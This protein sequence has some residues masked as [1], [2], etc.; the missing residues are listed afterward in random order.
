MASSLG[1]SAWMRDFSFS[2]CKVEVLQRRLDGGEGYSTGKDASVRFPTIMGV[3]NLSG[4]DGV[5]VWRV[6]YSMKIY[7]CGWGCTI[8]DGE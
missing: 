2:V 8:L 3:W 5:I 1:A 7:N 6:F 4:S